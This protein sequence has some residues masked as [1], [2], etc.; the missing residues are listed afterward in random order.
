MPSSMPGRFSYA[1]LAFAILSKFI[2]DIP[3]ADLKSICDKTYTAEVLLQCPRRRQRR[4]DRRCIGWRKENGK[5]KLGLLELPNGPT[6]AFKDMAM[7]LL[8]NLFEYVLAKR[9]EEINILGAT[10]RHR[11]GG[12]IRDA[13]QEGREASSCYRRTAHVGLPARPD[14]FA[15]GREHLQHRGHR[16]VR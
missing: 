3:A 8:G 11:F 16:H 13:R 5:G 7:Q 14:V 12:R 10:W 6:L 4:R 2:D 9:G 15:A 1:E